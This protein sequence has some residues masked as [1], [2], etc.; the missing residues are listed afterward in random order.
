M[1][2]ATTTL[3]VVGGKI[4]KTIKTAQVR[5]QERAIRRQE[6][7]QGDIIKRLQEGS[8]KINKE[9]AGQRKK[10]DPNSIQ[11]KKYPNG[12]EFDENGFARFEEYSVK[13][14]KF[15]FPSEEGLI[16]NRCL[17]GNYYHD[18]KLA[19]AF[20]GYDSTPEGYV[21]H[22]VEDMQTMLL[23]PQ[24]VHSSMM[25]GCSHTG[26]ACYIKKYIAEE[27]KK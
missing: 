21:W 20:I 5:R 17:N 2:A 12:V 4:V 3:M 11:A 14:V 10:F 25:G 13:S 23:V 26:G 22:H 8:K 27:M 9:Y 7:T 15:E 19:N 24:D 18:E 16:N 6:K 1:G